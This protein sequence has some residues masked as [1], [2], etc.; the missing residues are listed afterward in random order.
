MAEVQKA[1]GWKGLYFGGVTMAWQHRIVDV[2]AAT[3]KSLGV[4]HLISMN[5]ANDKA[6]VEQ[7]HPEV[8]I[9][10]FH[11]AYPPDTVTP[12]AS[13][14]DRTRTGCSLWL[15]MTLEIT[16]TSP[17]TK[18]RGACNRTISG[19]RVWVLVVAQPTWVSGPTARTVARQRVSES[20]YCTGKAGNEAACSA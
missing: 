14:V 12:L 19:E 3:E 9:F 7:P 5:I 17:T 6:E 18:K 20:G 4:R 16:A 1:S 8:S 15:R 2:I 13:K 11:Y 10:N